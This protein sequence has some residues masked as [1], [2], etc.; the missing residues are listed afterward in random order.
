MPQHLLALLIQTMLGTLAS[1][2]CGA[3]FTFAGLHAA[4]AIRYINVN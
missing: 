4:L 1:E 3:F 2:H